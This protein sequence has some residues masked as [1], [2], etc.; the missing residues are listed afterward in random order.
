MLNEEFD[1]QYD[2]AVERGKAQRAKL[3]IERT[4]RLKF[5][6][7]TFGGRSNH[8]IE[9]AAYLILEAHQSRRRAVW[10]YICHTVRGYVRGWRFSFEFNCRVWRYRFSG[11]NKQAAIE[12]ACDSL[13]D[14]HLLEGDERC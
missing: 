5:F 8:V 4:N 12:K 13:D 1:K 3:L 6:V 9:V 7:D 11:L 2:A 10:R 14:G